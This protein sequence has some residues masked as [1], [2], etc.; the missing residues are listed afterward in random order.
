[1]GVDIIDRTNGTRV[2][3]RREVRR[4]IDIGR[5]YG[6][7]VMSLGSP[8]TPKIDRSPASR[9]REDVDLVR[10]ESSFNM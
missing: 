4:Q 9:V 1:M 8:V 2:E 6:R 3:L 7:F 10:E 5:E